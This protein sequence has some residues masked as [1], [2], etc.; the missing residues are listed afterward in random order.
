MINRTEI[1]VF[2]TVLFYILIISGCRNHKTYTNPIVE[3]Y[4]ACSHYGSDVISIR[5]GNKFTRQNC[6]II[7]KNYY[8]TVSVSKDTLFLNYENKKAP[9]DELNYMIKSDSSLTVFVLYKSIKEKYSKLSSAE[10]KRIPKKE[11]Y[12][13]KTTSYKCKRTK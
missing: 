1:K 5:E 2:T 10:L 8:G 3:K 9:K 11:L 6:F 13:I 7:C 12:T 4:V